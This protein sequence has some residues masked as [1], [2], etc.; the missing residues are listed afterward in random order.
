MCSLEVGISLVH[1]GKIDVRHQW[2]VVFTSRDELA[3]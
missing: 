1:E 2:L 3:R